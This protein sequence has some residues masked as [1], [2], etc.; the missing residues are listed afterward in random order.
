MADSEKQH[1]MLGQWYVR[2]LSVDEADQ[3]VEQLQQRRQRAL[4]T[5][6]PCIC[7]QIGLLMGHFWQGKEIE[8]EYL[9]LR[10]KFAN[11]RR[12]LALLELIVGQLRISRQ[13]NGALQHLEQGFE[14]AHGLLTSAD[15]FLLVKRHKLLSRIPLQ[16]RAS[17]GKTL[18]E[19]TAM[20]AVIEQL[21]SS[22]TRQRAYSHSQN[23]F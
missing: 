21:E 15:Y 16:Q 20:A 2:P 18:Q 13:L 11:H 4:R 8:G 5:A 12:V 17:P 10:K 19:L 9:N 7:C 6:R 3:W 23:D 1:G 14:L 22:H